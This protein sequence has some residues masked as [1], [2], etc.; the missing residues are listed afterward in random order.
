MVRPAIRFL[1]CRAHSQGV[2]PREANGPVSTREHRFSRRTFAYTE[3]SFTTEWLEARSAAARVRSAGLAGRVGVPA[4][5]EQQD[6]EAEDV[7][8]GDVPAAA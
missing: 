5:D 4:E 8:D 2:D 7:A 1:L 6:E 3:S